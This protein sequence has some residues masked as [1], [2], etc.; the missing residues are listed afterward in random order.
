M[1]HEGEFT[2]VDDNNPDDTEQDNIWNRLCQQNTCRLPEYPLTDGD[3]TSFRNNEVA[4]EDD[5][6]QYLNE[7]RVPVDLQYCYNGLSNL[8]E[9]PQYSEYSQITQCNP[10]CN[11]TPSVS[12][13]GNDQTLD[14]S[15][16]SENYCVMPNNIYDGNN[17]NYN[18]SNIIDKLNQLQ[19][20][21]SI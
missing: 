9:P 21:Q 18:F 7:V 16:C 14:V 3:R 10:D 8:T 20:H 4:G 2:I 15:G 6:S 13:Q 1:I 5:I 17:I 19:E 12:C 11:G